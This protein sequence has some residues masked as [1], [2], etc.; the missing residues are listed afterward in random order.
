MKLLI[1][2]LTLMTSVAFAQTKKSGSFERQYGIAGCGLGSVLMGKRGAQLFAATTNGSFSNQIIGI[3]AGTLNCVDTPSAE[4]AGRMDLFI[5]V[6]MAQ[7]Q[8]DIARGNGE[9]IAALGNYMGCSASSENIGAV[10]KQNYSNIFKDEA[11]TNEVTDSIINAILEQNEIA[12][13]CNKLG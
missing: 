1:I 7:L 4:T 3:T 5:N 8:S 6:N 11:V 13:S 9:T 10:L 2:A 12:Q